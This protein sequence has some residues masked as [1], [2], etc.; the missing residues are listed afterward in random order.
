MRFLN[1]PQSKA[2]L[3]G[4][5]GGGLG[6]LIAE[7]IIGVPKSFAATAS[8]GCLTGL[9]IGAMFGLAEGLAVGSRIIALR[10]ALIG[11]CLGIVG[12][13]AG[14]SLAQASYSRSQSTATDS[15]S[16]FSVEEQERLQQAGAKS[17]EVEIGLFWQNSN[18]LDLHVIDPSG[19]RIFLAI[20]CHQ[21]VESLMLIAMPPVVVKS[22]ISPWSTLCGRLAL[23]L[24]VNI[25]CKWIISS[26]VVRPMQ[27][28]LA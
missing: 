4:I 21:H 18:D 5:L 6:W 9:G 26:H 17:G 7:L 22:R 24:R 1:D 28:L 27:P 20:E 25:L 2:V 12:G 13:G 16:V 19:E 15:G 11:G 14:A 10:G 3:A 8:Y 23:R